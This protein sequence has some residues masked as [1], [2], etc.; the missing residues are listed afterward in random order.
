M[1]A[2]D[3][4]GRRQINRAAQI[5]TPQC[6]LLRRHAEPSQVGVFPIGRRDGTAR[7]NGDRLRATRQIEMPYL[8]VA[9]AT[10]D[11][12]AIDQ[13]MRIG[14][15]RPAESVPSAPTQK[16]TGDASQRL[17][18]VISVRPKPTQLMGRVTPARLRIMSPGRRV[19]IG[20]APEG[21]AIKVPRR[22]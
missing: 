2:V 4:V 6:D 5:M 3:K 17:R 13:K 22:K 8:P 10:L 9:A 19:S 1:P 7:G 21:V 20:A 12:A 11:P 18:G 16:I 15:G 14:V